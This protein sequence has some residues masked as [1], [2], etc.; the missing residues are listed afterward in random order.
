MPQV[1]AQEEP[2]LER[3]TRSRQL[4]A[5]E[6]SPFDRPQLDKRQVE[7]MEIFSAAPTMP[8]D[9]IRAQ[10]GVRR[11]I[12]KR[13]MEEDDEFK[14]A[15]QRQYNITLRATNMSR[16]RV[17]EG[18]LDA[19]DMAKGNRQATGMISGWKEV[20]RMCGFYEPERREVTLS[21][22]SK[23]VIEDMKTMSRE[24]LLELVQQQDVIEG[25]LIGPPTTEL[26]DE[27]SS[28]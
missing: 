9:D 20:G 2:E 6:N 14:R 19:I 10:V 13:W 5:E 8:L 21:I 26:E 1:A 27:E 25:E 12:F 17:M 23:Q 3:L 11:V 4:R 7:F 24:R 18:F 15:L 22:E 16:K 28:N